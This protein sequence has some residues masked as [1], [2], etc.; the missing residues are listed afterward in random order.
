MWSLLRL[1]YLQHGILAIQTFSFA[2]LTQI[3]VVSNRTC[4]SHTF[5]WCCPTSVTNNAVVTLSLLAG[6][7]DTKIFAEKTLKSRVT[8]VSNFLFDKFNN[9]V[10]SFHSIDAWS[11]ALL[12]WSSLFVFLGSV[13]FEA[14]HL[15]FNALFTNKFTV[16]RLLFFNKLFD[17]IYSFWNF[18]FFQN[19]DRRNNFLS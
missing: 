8:E 7:F 18:H 11:T 4:E 12:A 14:S 3:V 15:V 5:D 19:L 10:K 13:T 2:V 6:T 17:L 1:S 9:L 16:R